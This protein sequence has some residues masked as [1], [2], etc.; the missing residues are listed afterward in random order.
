MP[1]K[2]QRKLVP[3]LTVCSTVTG[4]AYSYQFYWFRLAIEMQREVAKE[5]LVLKMLTM[6]TKI[7]PITTQKL[8]MLWSLLRVCL[9]NAVTLATGSG[10]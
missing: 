8:N 10:Q 9:H 2:R 4:D 1:M 6:K 3:L 5:L 7:T